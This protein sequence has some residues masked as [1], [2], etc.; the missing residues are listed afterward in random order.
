MATSVFFPQSFSGVVFFATSPK[1]YSYW[2]VLFRTC[3]RV[4]LPHFLHPL[5]ISNATVFILSTNL[6][7]G[8]ALSHCRIDR[9][10]DRSTT[11]FLYLSP[12]SSYRAVFKY[13]LCFT[14]LLCLCLFLL[15]WDF[16]FPPLPSPFCAPEAL[17]YFF[18]PFSFLA[19]HFIYSASS[20]SSSSCP[21]SHSS[22]FKC[23]ISFVSFS[24]QLA[25]FCEFHFF[26]SFSL[27]LCCVKALWSFFCVLFHILLL[28]FHLI[29]LGLSSL[30]ISHIFIV[31]EGEGLR[32]SFYSKTL[33]KPLMHQF[34][35]IYSFVLTSPHSLALI[36]SLVLNL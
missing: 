19:F 35:L 27:F 12:S 14:L 23:V 6:F 36:F 8:S 5:L 7:F 18:L 15:P 21:S 31:C 30:G 33:R 11:E 4:F 16:F 26:Y 20:S 22:S 17:T 2:K 9:Q 28:S 34:L 10:T 29:F 32:D 25:S 1:Q 13:L 24:P 3:W